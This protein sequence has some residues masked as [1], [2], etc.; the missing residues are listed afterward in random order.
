MSPTLFQFR[1]SCCS[2]TLLLLLSIFLLPESLYSQTSSDP[3]AATAPVVAEAAAEID[4]GG[5]CWAGGDYPGIGSRGTL[6][7]VGDRYNLSDCLL[8]LRHGIEE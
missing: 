2:R 3:V 5:H 4:S 8:L 7:R 6:G 1:V